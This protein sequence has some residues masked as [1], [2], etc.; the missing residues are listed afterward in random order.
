MK[1][2]VTRNTFKRKDGS[3]TTVIL[4]SVTGTVPATLKAASKDRLNRLWG[5]TTQDTKAASETV[6]RRICIDLDLFTTGDLV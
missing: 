5:S 4:D 1:N 6:A 3:Y 2:L